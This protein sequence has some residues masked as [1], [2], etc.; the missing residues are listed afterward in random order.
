VLE[1]SQFIA[2]GWTGAL[3]AYW[4]ADVIKVEPPGLGDGIRKWR[5]LDETGTSLWWYSIARNKKSLAVDLRQDEGRDI[6]RQLVAKCDVLVENFKPG[7]LEKWHMSPTTLRESHPSLI[8]ARISGYGQTGP[9]R[10]KPG[11]ASVCEAFGGFRYVNGMPGGPPIRPNLSIGDTL[12]AQNAALG[13]LLALLSRQKASATGGVG[14]GQDV[15]CAIYES[16]FGLMEACVPEYDRLGEV[17][18]PAGTTVT[19]IVPT[20]TY[21][22]K[23]G[24]WVVIGA[25]GDSLFKRLMVAAGRHDL[26]DD[27]RLAS[28]E[29]RVTHQEEV[30]GAIAA[31]TSTLASHEVQQI[32]EAGLVSVPVGTIYSVRDMCSDPHYIARG[33]FEQVHTGPTQEPLKI[34]AIPPKLTKTP[35]QTNWAGPRLGEHTKEILAGLLGMSESGLSD[36]CEKRIIQAE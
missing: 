4:G 12:A 7:T 26:A 17:R 16:V 13:V 15:D 3:L 35:G 19:G 27:P 36:L 6:I 14:E 25:N 18:E 21:P 31:W 34:P 11:F 22:C 1:L 28:N 32:L 30:D 20:G 9:Y 10:S 5:K 8:V 33:M 23:D 2:G 29:G 24:H